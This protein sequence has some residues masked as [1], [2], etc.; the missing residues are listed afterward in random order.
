MK[1]K[2]I[3]NLKLGKKTIS[4]F[5]KNKVKGGAFLSTWVACVDD[6]SRVQ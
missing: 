3:K 2:S 4:K 6:T 1:Q 5:N